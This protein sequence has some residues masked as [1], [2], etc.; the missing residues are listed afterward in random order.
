MTPT[1]DIERILFTGSMDTTQL[2]DF[3]DDLSFINYEDCNGISWL[4]T[5]GPIY[6]THTD[7]CGTGQVEAMSNVGGDEDY[8]E[9][10]F[11]QPFTKQELKETLTAAAVDPFG[12]YY[13]DG[14][15]YWNT[16]LIVDWW[17]KSN[18]R[19]AYILE[20]Y[21]D[22][23]N[24]PDVLDRPLYGPRNPIPENYKSWLDFYQNGMK[25]YLEWY[26]LKLSNKQTKLEDIKFDWTRKFEF[27]N[28]LKSKQIENKNSR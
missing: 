7:N 12:A 23:L 8:C 20:R 14:N 3:I 13:F 10:I 21:C 5:P 11:K 9:V 27:D 22:E 17:S 18:E 25:A 19:I 2:T 6:T 28:L 1:S 4:N 16:E 24:L 26:I 15:Q